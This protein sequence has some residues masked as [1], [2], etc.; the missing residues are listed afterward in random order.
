LLSRFDQCHAQSELDAARYA[1]LGAPRVS[2]TGNLKLEVPAPP[3]DDAKLAQ[4]KA[5]VGGRPVF[6]AASTHAGE[7]SLII[8]AH[9][10]LKE[11]FPGLLTMIVP[12]HPERGPGVAEI[13]RV[14]GLSAALRSEGGLPDAATDVYVADTIGE[15]GV[16]YRI[17]PIV[18]LGGSL[19]RH[20][21]QNPIEAAKLGATILHGPHV[22]NFR[23]I[24]AAL[25]QAEGAALVADAHNLADLIAAWLRDETARRAVSQ[26]AE[27]AV[28]RLGGALQRTLTA[29]EPYLMQLRLEH[30]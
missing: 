10:R 29:I 5:A 4:L 1:E 13:A 15:L 20:G 25:D 12:R 24:Y 28:E 7:E 21:G 16:F 23:E 9:R 3:A 22:W 27:T 19:V 8:E 14:A 18:F 2:L 30:R 26:R 6:A 17:A 11:S